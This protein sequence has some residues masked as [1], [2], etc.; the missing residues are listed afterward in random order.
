MLSF[1]IA[2]F[3]KKSLTIFGS[4]LYG[5]AIV[6]TCLDYFLEGSVMLLWVWDKVRVKESPDPCWFSWAILAVWP[7]T[8][9]MGKFGGWTK[10]SRE[11]YRATPCLLARNC[12]K[13]SSSNII[14]D[15]RSNKICRHQHA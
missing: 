3:L 14:K 15:N 1:H 6:T 2:F 13:A 5:S 4:S 7:G 8:M 12:V 11:Q 10:G 9:I